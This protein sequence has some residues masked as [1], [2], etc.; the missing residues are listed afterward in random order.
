M[1]SGLP[2]PIWMELQRLHPLPALLRNAVNALLE[3]GAHDREA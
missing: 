2:L 3:A 1:L